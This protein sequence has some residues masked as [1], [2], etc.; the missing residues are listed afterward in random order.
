MK[1]KTFSEWVTKNVGDLGELS[2]PNAGMQIMSD[3]TLALNQ[4]DQLVDRV[5]GI[6]YNVSEDRRDELMEIFISN[7]QSRL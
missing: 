7:L 3:E 4:L 2:T 1:K 6:L 5:R